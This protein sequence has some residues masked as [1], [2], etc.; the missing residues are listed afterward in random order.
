[1]Q[2]LQQRRLLFLSLGV[3]ER[4]PFAASGTWHVSLDALFFL[5]LFMGFGTFSYS[6][7]AIV[8]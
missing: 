6:K 5:I 7:G 2:R 1:M 4:F 3:E 8:R